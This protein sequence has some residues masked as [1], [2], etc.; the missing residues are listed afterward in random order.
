MQ[1]LHVHINAIPQNFIQLLLCGGK[2]YILST[3]TQLLGE[4]LHFP[5]TLTLRQCSILPYYL[6]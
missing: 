6:S 3:N 4:L 2:F 5:K 1:L